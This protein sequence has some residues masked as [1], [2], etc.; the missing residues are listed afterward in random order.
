M[1]MNKRLFALAVFCATAIALPA[2]VYAD[3]GHRGHHHHDNDTSVVIAI[4]GLSV[5]LGDDVFAN[6]WNRSAYRERAA[7]CHDVR[8]DCYFY[9]R[10][11][12]ACHLR[13]KYCS[14]GQRDYGYYYNP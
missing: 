8:R 3:R 14:P 13:W 2:S 4:P 9:G 7:F 1:S 5:A 6:S 12:R 11:S 10:H